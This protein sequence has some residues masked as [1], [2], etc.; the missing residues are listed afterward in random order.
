[1]GQRRCARCRTD[2]SPRAP[3]TTPSGC[4]TSEPAPR[5]P[6]WK[7]DAPI[8][9]LT[10]LSNGHLVAGDSSGVCIGWRWW[11]ERLP[12]GP[13]RRSRRLGRHLR[14]RPQPDQ[15]ADGEHEIG[16]VHRIKVQFL[17]AVVDEVDHLL[18]ADRGGDEA[19]SSRPSNRQPPTPVEEGFRTSKSSGRCSLM[20]IWQR[21][22]ATHGRRRE[23][24][25]AIEKRRAEGMNALKTL[26]EL[27]E[28]LETS[29]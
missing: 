23:I 1:M 16:A 12:L 5:P 18:G 10:T 19:V 17:D 11:T 20:A 8:R 14:L 6:A 2:G 28:N 9:C 15:M 3:M 13:S 21:S 24:L 7:L 22:K 26:K 4:G 29:R 25:A 27:I